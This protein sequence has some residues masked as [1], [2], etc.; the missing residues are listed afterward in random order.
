MGAPKKPSKVPRNSLTSA[1]P[2]SICKE[3]LDFDLGM[4]LLH[5]N[6]KC[7][8]VFSTRDSEDMVN[9]H[10]YFSSLPIS[11]TRDAPASA[12]AARY[13]S[14][15]MVR[16][17]AARISCANCVTFILSADE[18]SITRETVPSHPQYQ[19][20]LQAR[21]CLQGDS[22]GEQ[23]PLRDERPVTIPEL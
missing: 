11:E 18:T 19:R 12:T 6:R 20:Q 22:E 5:K 3:V 8:A 14:L 23:V 16:T 2:S 17:L 4:E 21:A 15:L 7:C 10:F 9:G 1:A 13:T